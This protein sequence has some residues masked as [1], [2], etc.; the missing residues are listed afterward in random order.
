[1][2]ADKVT[3]ED[4]LAGLRADQFAN[5]R[6]TAKL[7]MRR[8]E[9]H[10]AP[11][12]GGQR[13]N[14]ITAGAVDSAVARWLDTGVA[15]GEINLRLATLRRAF[16]I[17]VDG[18]RIPRMPRVRLL[19]LRNARTGFLE[20]WQLDEVLAHLPE[21]LRAPVLFGYL[22]GWRLRSEVLSLAWSQVDLDDGSVR[23]EPNQTKGGEG[24]LLFATGE[25]R[26]LLE[27]C[28]VHR[29]PACPYVFHHGGDRIL[30]CDKAWRTAVTAAGRQGLL[31]HDMRRSAV[32]NYVRAG[33]S[34]RVAM[35]LCGHR[36][37][38]VFDR[39]HIVAE[40]DLKEAAQRMDQLA[41]GHLPRAKR[42]SD[43]APAAGEQ[44]SNGHNLGHNRPASAQQSTLTH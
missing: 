37:R 28:W 12:F 43:N 31:M 18:E 32:R 19:A 1:V 35:A 6:R 22:S 5:R 40:G 10:L 29:I 44:T 23:I 17:A 20:R 36:T 42:A 38:A 14:E 26:A 15:P 24:R 4:L 9:L 16:R 21:Y 41:A 3:F 30:R 33:V 25:M 2:G 7:T 27:G 8:A 13:A 39:Y 11:I 34:E